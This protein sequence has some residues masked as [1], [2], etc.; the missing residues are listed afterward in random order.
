M[1]KML[2]QRILL[3]MDVVPVLIFAYYGFYKLPKQKR[4]G[5]LKAN[6]K[7]IYYIQIGTV[8]VLLLHTFPRILKLFH[9]QN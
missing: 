3:A 4:E 6:P 9:S 7:V 2:L 8:A 5:T 1:S